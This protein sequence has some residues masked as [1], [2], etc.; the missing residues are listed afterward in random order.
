V[1]GRHPPFP[2]RS[3]SA[4]RMQ[5]ARRIRDHRSTRA[6]RAHLLARQEGLEPPTTWFE[7]T[8]TDSIFQLEQSLATLAAFANPT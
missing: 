3:L 1:Q 6:S 8:P 5:K 4:S 2:A 7:V